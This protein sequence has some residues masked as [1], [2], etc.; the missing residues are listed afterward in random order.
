[1]FSIKKLAVAVL[2]G[3]A[4]MSAQAAGTKAEVMHWWTSAG[5]SAAIK[6]I[7][8]AYNAAGG[9]WVDSAVAGGDQA[10]AAAINRMIGGNP[11]TAAQFNTSK[12]FTDL[13]TE[14]MLNAV[15]VAIRA[16]ARDARLIDDASH[17]DWA[18]LDGVSTV[19]VT[20][21]A[22]APE[23]L[24]QAVVQALQARFDVT[25]ADDPGERETVTFKLPRALTT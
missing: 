11:P 17:I 7:A 19:G 20:A 23:P 15:E 12:Q 14:G 25:L 9:E 3:C 5:E 18:W 2:V 4:A 6:E 10:R 16:G 1:M 8:D 13:I 24:V 22:S 21:G